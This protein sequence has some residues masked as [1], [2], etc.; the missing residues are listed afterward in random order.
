MRGGGSDVQGRHRIIWGSAALAVALIGTA[1][2]ALAGDASPRDT[3]VRRCTAEGAGFYYIPGSDTCLRLGGYLWTETYLNSY[4]DYPARNDRL[5][6]VA[7]Y[8]FEM[9]ARTATEYG[10]L[11]S[12]IELRMIWRTADPFSGAP[13]EP[14]FQPR[15][16]RV[17]FGGLT[18]GLT[19]SFFDFYGN[20]NVLGTDPGTIGDQ[21]QLP[22]LGYTWSLANGYTAQLSI[23]DSAVRDVGVLS[24]DATVPSDSFRPATRLP[25]FVGTFGQNADWGQFQLSGALHQIAAGAGSDSVIGTSSHEWGYALQAG[26]MFNLPQIATGDT[27][28]LQAAYADGAIS[29][30]GLIDPSGDFTAPDAFVRGDG[31]LARARGWSVVGQYLHNWNANWNSAIFGGYGTFDITDALARATYGASSVANINAGANL[32]WTPVAPLSITLQYD[33]NLYQAQDWHPT[34][35]SLPV[36]SQQAHQL[37]LMFARTF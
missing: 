19:Q 8:G 30:L 4:T 28:Y 16:M 9:D 12:Y 37:M 5:Y 1:P 18:A 35:D 21:T 23:E 6:W 3:S 34:A 31:S 24:A 13:S 26:V 25:D 11:R 7:T 14:F 33:Y 29:Y 15:N 32:T 10:T 2:A 22:L 27:L 17:E 20:A 36:A